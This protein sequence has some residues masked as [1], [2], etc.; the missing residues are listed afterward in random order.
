MIT[1]IQPDEM[2]GEIINDAIY[3]RNEFVKEKLNFEL[4]EVHA[5]RIDDMAAHMQTILLAG[6]D[7]YDAAF[8]PMYF[9][10]SAIS[11]GQYWCLNDVST[12]HLDEEYWDSVMINDTSIGGKNYFAA[13]SVHLMSWDGL[14]CLFFNEDMM[15]SLNIEYPYQLVRDGKWTLDEF[16]KYCKAAANLNG[17]DSFTLNANGKSVFGC[18]SFPSAPMKFTYALGANYVSKDKDD[19][20]II[21]FD[22]ERFINVCQKLAEYFG[23]SGEYLNATDETAPDTSYIKMYKDQRAMFIGG[24]IKMAQVMRDMDQSFGIVPFPKFDEMQD[25]YRSTALHQE[26]VFV[27]PYTNKNPED[28][29]LVFDALSYESQERVLGPYFSV[30]VEQKGLRNEESIEMLN[31]IKDTRSFDIGVS[32]QWVVSLEELIRKELLQGSS[33]IAS[34]IEQNKSKI[35]E[36][37]NKTVEKMS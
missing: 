2:N 14:W 29:G 18:T 34:L 4:E 23:R 24:E 3:S 33:N 6:E 9:V 11:D 25:N 22:S 30:V 27:I 28:V 17:E 13:S 21:S 16:S 5:T 1:V 20:P 7:I 31:I 32:Y 10:G 8:M 37:I 35:Q 19:M 26:P 15:D 12:L 36:S